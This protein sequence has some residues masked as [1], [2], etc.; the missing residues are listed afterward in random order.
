[1][2]SRMGS[3]GNGFG[4]VGSAAAVAATGVGPGAVGAMAGGFAAPAAGEL[5]FVGG[6]IIV[7]VGLIAAGGG[8]A[9]EPY[10]VAVPRES[11]ELAIVGALIGADEELGGGFG[12]S[13]DG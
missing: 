5:R 4:I 12:F 11:F 13:V 9:S 10:V 8:D 7:F 6:S 1:M 2:D 3:G